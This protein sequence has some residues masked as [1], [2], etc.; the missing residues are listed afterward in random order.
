MGL[1]RL[2]LGQDLLD[3]IVW[4]EVIRLLFVRRRR[5]TSGEGTCGFGSER[6]LHHD[7]AGWP[8]R[9]SADS[10]K[11]SPPYCAAK[12]STGCAAYNLFVALHFL[13]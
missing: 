5:E 13:A 9:A 7:L 3:Q 2:L 12:W 11:G 4:A 1:K 6:L 10:E 8:L